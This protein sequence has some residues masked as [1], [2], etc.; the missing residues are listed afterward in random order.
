RS[1]SPR[2]TAVTRGL[3]T[4]GSR[5]RT[6]SSVAARAQTRLDQAQTQRLIMVLMMKVGIVVPFSWSYIG[7]VGEHAEGQAAALEALGVE[8]RVLTGDDPPGSVSRLFH[9]DAP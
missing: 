7:G 8:T 5:R 2:P 6:R 4:L 3:L 9:P 1:L